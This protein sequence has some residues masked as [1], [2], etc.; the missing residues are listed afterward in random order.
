MLR[1]VFSLDAEVEVVET[2]LFIGCWGRSC[3]DRSFHW[4][5]RWKLLR[6][7]FLLDVDAVVETGLLIGCWVGSWRVF[8]LAVEG[9]HGWTLLFII[10][11]EVCLL[12]L[13]NTDIQIFS[14]LCAAASVLRVH[15]CFLSPVSH[16]YLLIGFRSDRRVVLCWPVELMYAWTGFNEAGHCGS[17]DWKLGGVLYWHGVIVSQWVVRSV[18]FPGGVLYWHGVIVSLWVVRSVLFPCGVLYWHGGH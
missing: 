8:S 17:W 9:L 5:L 4:T 18:L 14:S 7:V 11:A 12:D 15:C 1:Q 3:W 16:R 10:Y 13:L 2:V 6:Q